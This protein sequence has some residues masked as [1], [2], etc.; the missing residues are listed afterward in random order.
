MKLQEFVSETVREII[1]G[2]HEAQTYAAT[3]GAT[4]NPIEAGLR[5]EKK[6]YADV[7]VRGDWRTVPI[8]DI[9]FDVAVTS[10]DTSETQA[11]AGIFVAGLGLGAKGKSDTSNSSVS[12]IRFSVPVTFPLQGEHVCKQSNVAGGN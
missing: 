2:V 10:T 6:S 11:G 7:M 9:D 4:V 12:R 5:Q 3:A 1:A 8:K